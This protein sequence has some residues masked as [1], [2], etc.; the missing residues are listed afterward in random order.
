MALS[1]AVAGAAAFTTAPIAANAG[2]AR[3]T[4]TQMVFGIFDAST[5]SPKLLKALGI[6]KEP[7]FSLNNGKLHQ[8]ILRPKSSISPELRAAVGLPPAP[9]PPPFNPF[10]GRGDGDNG[11]SD[12]SLPGL[13]IALGAA[14]VRC[15]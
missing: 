2:R 13:A 1:L 14:G 15:T 6:E 10:G 4:D 9:P 11:D 7:T 8:S 3:V 5:P 12:L